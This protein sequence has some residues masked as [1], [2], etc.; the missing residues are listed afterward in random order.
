MLLPLK[1]NWTEIF[2]K[3]EGKQ[4]NEFRFKNFIVLV[5]LNSMIGNR[6]YV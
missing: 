4:M 6:S 2:R 3:V 1:D 5:E